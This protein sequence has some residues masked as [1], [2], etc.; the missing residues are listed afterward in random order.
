MAR[1]RTAGR[2]VTAISDRN[3]VLLNGY[4]ALRNLQLIIPV[5]VPFC[6]GHIG[7]SFHEIVL[8]E[9]AFAAT[10]VLIEIPSGWLADHWQRRRVMILGGTFNWLASPTTF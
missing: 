3:T 5:F 9:A 4:T 7:L 10:M 6:M 2:D 1:D 8:S